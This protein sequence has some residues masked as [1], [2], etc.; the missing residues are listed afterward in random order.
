[1]SVLLEYPALILVLAK[2][3]LKYKRKHV[4]SMEYY[5]LDVLVINSVNYIKIPISS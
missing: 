2:I 3:S 1:V 4:T 5:K